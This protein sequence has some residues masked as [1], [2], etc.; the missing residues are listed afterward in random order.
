MAYYEKSTRKKDKRKI[1]L[2]HCVLRLNGTDFIFPTAKG[3]FTWVAA[4]EKFN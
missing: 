2:K 1:L 3:D 4:K